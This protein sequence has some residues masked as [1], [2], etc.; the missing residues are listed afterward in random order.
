MTARRQTNWTLLASV[1]LSI[2]SAAALGCGRSSESPSA[3][4]DSQAQSNAA[5][6]VTAHV[7]PYSARTSDSSADTPAPDRPTVAADAP[8]DAA[9]WPFSSD[10]PWNTSLGSN[11]QYTTIDSPAFSADE[12]ANL[13][14]ADW[15]YPVFIAKPGDRQRKFYW[16]DGNE[17]I[18]T[19]RAPD[20]ARPDA[21]GDG[22]L[23]IINDRHDTV[24]EMW[25]ASRLN[26]GD[27][28]GS[29]TVKHDL[30]GTGFYRDY[31]GTRAGGMAATG[32]LIR[33]DELIDRLIPHALAVAVKPKAMNRHAPGRK[34]Y[35]WPASWA[36]GGNGDGYSTAGNLHMGSLLAVPPDVDIKTLGLSPQGL[37]VARA[38]Q[39]Y[40]AYVVDQ[41]G[42][43]IIYYAEPASA[44]IL[45]T[46]AEELGRLT[47]YLKVVPN[48]AKSNVG[49][50]GKPR[51]APAK[52]LRSR[53]R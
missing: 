30:R 36:D 6:A 5:P 45:R 21:Q 29:V 50:G 20:D 43:N 2:C 52:A 26:N 12:G 9:L 35:V 11:A 40:G 38:L 53:L 47:K 15:S 16:R 24:V 31:R 3:T 49:G 13:N 37:A 17:L 7:P 18:A 34:P 42:G 14:V 32:G 46:S 33:R 39:D 28:E 48:N 41:G 51:R 25:Q 44:D 23:L 19:I 8:R 1:G 4:A 10:S 22:S 27:W